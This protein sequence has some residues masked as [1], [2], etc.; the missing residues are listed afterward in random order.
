M[1]A[2]LCR[3]AEPGA[4]DSPTT[5]PS[6][7]PV[8][9]QVIERVESGSSQGAQADAVQAFSV[10]EDPAPAYQR[11]TLEELATEILQSESK[12]ASNVTTPAQRT[13]S[14]IHGS[15]SLHG[16]SSVNIAIS[17]RED[18]PPRMSGKHREKQPEVE[19]ITDEG[20]ITWQRGELIGAGAF[21]RVYMGMNQENGQLLAVKQVAIQNAS[22]PK[23]RT[24]E[25]VAALEAE[26]AVLRNLNHPNIVRYLGTERDDEFLNIF[27]E[28]V[29]GGSIASLL[30]K[31]GPFSEKVIRMYTQQLLQGL[32]FLHRHQIMHRDIKG[33]NLLVDNNGIVKLADFGA[34]K[35]LA[36]I[37]TM[38][39][40]FKSMKGTPYWMAPEVIKQTGHGRPADIWSVGCTV[41][42]MAT[43]KPPWSEFASQV[44]AL[45]HIASSQSS[46][47]LPEFL[48]AEAEDFLH[49]CFNRDPKHPFIANTQPFTVLSATPAPP[50]KPTRPAFLAVSIQEGDIPIPKSASGTQPTFWEEPALQPAASAVST[51]SAPSVAL[52]D[53]YRQYSH[54]EFQQ[55]PPAV[56]PAAPPQTELDPGSPQSIRELNSPVSSVKSEDNPIEEPSWDNFVE[57]EPDRSGVYANGNASDVES[58]PGHRAEEEPPGSADSLKRGRQAGSKPSLPPLADVPPADEEKLMNYVRAKAADDQERLMTPFRRERDAAAAP[59]P[60]ASAGPPQQGV[61]SSWAEASPGTLTREEDWNDQMDED[62][63]VITSTVTTP[64]QHTPKLGPQSTRG[65][66]RAGG[67]ERGQRPEKRGGAAAPAAPVSKIRREVLP[68]RSTPEVRKSPSNAAQTVYGASQGGSRSR[69]PSKAAPQGSRPITNSKRIEQSPLRRSPGGAGAPK[70][71]RQSSVN[72]SR[73]SGTPKVGPRHSADVQ[74]VDTYVAREERVQ[75]AA[76]ANIVEQQRQNKQA[77]WEEELQKELEHQR[78]E[79]RRQMAQQTRDIQ[80][81]YESSIRATASPTKL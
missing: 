8:E 63:L 47:P 15:S 18:S 27:L 77:Q 75:V 40:G 36:D 54:S 64:T 6:A 81:V 52:Q 49:L 72:A 56:T 60:A 17:E 12:Q 71:Q 4:S 46:P 5:S 68:A 61:N 43:G 26:V 34:S 41:I 9:Q 73:S 29:P 59:E 50:T 11:S 79:K 10:S 42:E 14:T 31:F 37:V 80:I 30:M 28:Y 51:I 32:E 76:A 2:K 53:Q 1:G 78:A 67:V 24:E 13:P 23:E 65:V 3:G 55:T 16:L 35:K 44:S 38:D 62:N 21:G 25:H 58:P 45:F 19:S 22:T 7:A 66:G 39:S 57:G 69:T 70:P 20:G 33:A 74:Q 48:S